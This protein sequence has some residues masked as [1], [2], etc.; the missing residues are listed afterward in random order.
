MHFFFKGRRNHDIAVKERARLDVEEREFSEPY[1][2]LGY[3]RTGE[4]L[5]G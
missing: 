5:E 1:D 4:D 2:N 3:W